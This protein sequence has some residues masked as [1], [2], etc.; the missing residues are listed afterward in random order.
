M[1]AEDQLTI[2]G[3]FS[4]H[5][6]QRPVGVADARW[7]G[8]FWGERFELC[9]QV[10]VPEM[11]KAMEDD[12]NGAILGNFR[13]GAGLET[14]K[15]RGTNWS[16]GDCYKWLETQAWLFA[17]T[18][19][20]TLDREMDYWIDL[21]AKTQADDGY[22]GTQTQ[23][24]PDKPRW[25]QRI[26]HELYNHGHLMTAAAVHKQATGKDNFLAVAV[27][28][29]DYLDRTFS[30][31]PKELAAFGWN[32]S[33]IMGLVDL[34]RVTG[35]RRYLRLA[36]VF[37]DMRGSIKWPYSIWGLTPREIDPHPGDQNQNRVPLRDETVAVGHAV[38]G[39]YLW[40]G[41][42]D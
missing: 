2:T 20:P 8:G 29:A 38:T 36:G 28:L 1:N 33:N 39:P 31:R 40:C 6:A 26:Y 9:R 10:I 27:K 17:V 5:T 18:R 25:G 42:A 22:I 7:T 19:D 12:R 3:G 13:V 21:I 37:I 41:S 34:Y 14:G 35:E 15:H 16:D 4:P 23:L 32:P 24:D 11:R 30:P